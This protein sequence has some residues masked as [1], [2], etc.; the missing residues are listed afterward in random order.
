MVRVIVDGTIRVIIAGTRD[1][2]NYKLLESSLNFYLKNQKLSNVE[3]V[4]GN[5]KGADQL[6]ERY[7]LEKGIKL[8]IFPANWEEHGKSAGF[9]RNKQM[10]EYASYC[11]VF[12]DGKSKGSKLMIELATQ[13]KC[14]LRVIRY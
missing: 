7:A 12:W 14:I 1:F 11:V 2:N 9:I 5:C 10:A 6:G 4:S 3:I 13:Y 8:K